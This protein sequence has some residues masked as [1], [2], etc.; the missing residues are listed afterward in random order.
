L[1]LVNVA[2]ASSPFSPLLFVNQ[3]RGETRHNKNT[4]VQ[5]AEKLRGGGESASPPPPPKENIDWDS[6]GFGLNGVSTDYMWVDTIDACSS[7]SSSDAQEEQEEEYYYSKNDELNLQPLKALQIHP[8]ATVLNYGQALFE[9][10]KAFRRNDG[11]LALFRPDRNAAR[12]QLGA[13][14]ILLPPVPTDVFVHAAKRVVQANAQW[15]PPLNKGA[16]Y[17]RPLLM[18]TGA[19]L[20]VA[21]SPSSTFC[22]YASPVG[23]YFKGKGLRCLT[24]RAVTEYTRA[25]P[26]G[27]GGIKAAGNYAPAFLPQSIVKQEGYDEALFLDAVSHSYIEEAGA[28]NFFCYMAHNAT[29]VT[30]PLSEGTILPGVTRESIMILAR[31][32]CNLVVQERP[33]SLQE[34]REYGTEAFCCGTG[35]SIAPVGCIVTVDNEDETTTS[36]ILFNRAKNRKQCKAGPMTTKLYHMLRDIQ[37]GTASSE[38]QERYSSWIQIIE[39]APTTD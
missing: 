25:A 39:P 32:E 30:P 20:G 4:K 38:L 6:F 26:G 18:G 31:D 11:S 33:L 36:M 2:S 29:L 17:L 34:V 24:L 27:A 3:R 23:N 37:M 10:C 21:P 22:I 7:S 12:M 28:S 8:A 5:N 15:V 19:Q 14:R 16:L 13:K 35:A 1:V 9:G